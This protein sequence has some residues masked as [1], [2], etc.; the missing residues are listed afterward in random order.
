L[1]EDIAAA[2]DNLA[3]L[4]M[5]RRVDVGCYREPM[6]VTLEQIE[7]AAELA[8][9]KGNLDDLLA[10]LRPI[11]EPISDWPAVDLE[12]DL[13]RLIKLGNP[14]QVANVPSHGL[15]RLREV[16]QEFEGPRLIAIGF[17]NDAGLVAPKRLI[18]SA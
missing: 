2:Q 18:R 15:L 3:H 1:A 5:L 6:M 11:E 12:S 13:A 16:S 10:L 4:V 17:V 9:D 14:V 7:T 8:S